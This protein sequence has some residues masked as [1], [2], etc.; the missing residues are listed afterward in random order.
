MLL[1]HDQEDLNVLRS[2][3]NF[4]SEQAA[5]NWDRRVRFLKELANARKKLQN[6]HLEGHIE[7][8]TENPDDQASLWT[9]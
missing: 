2:H 6:T 3:Y 5:A 8:F 9:A 7:V 1:K 4:S